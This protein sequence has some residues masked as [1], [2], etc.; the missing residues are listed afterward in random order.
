[1]TATGPASGSLYLVPLF[2]CRASP[3]SCGSVG[4]S[5][6]SLDLLDFVLTIV[7]AVSIWV[8]DRIRLYCAEGDASTN[9]YGPDP[10]AA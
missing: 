3:P 1:M 5:L 8:P 10:L 6:E 4:K 7:L 2:G 9:R